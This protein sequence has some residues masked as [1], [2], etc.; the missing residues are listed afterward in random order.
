VR[1]LLLMLLCL[2]AVPA[3]AS[4]FEPL[5]LKAGVQERWLSGGDELD[6]HDLEATGAVMVP[7]TSH[8]AATGSVIYGLAGSYVRGD[9]DARFIVTDG[10]DLNLTMWIGA[11]RFFSDEASDGLD[12]WAGKAGVGYKPFAGLPFLLDFTA[13]YGLDSSRRSLSLGLSYPFKALVR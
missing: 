2:C 11:G 1:Y 7:I 3:I 9:A 12:E 10:Y 6:S 8:L 13:A 4:P 5:N